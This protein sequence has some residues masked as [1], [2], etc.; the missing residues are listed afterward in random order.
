MCKDVK[1]LVTTC[2]I[3]QQMKD[4][5]LHPATLLQFLPIPNQIFEDIAMD[6]ITCLPSSKGKF[7]I[8]T[9]VDRLTKYDHFIP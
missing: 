6:F 5:N 7:T 9:V 4:T 3:C 1:S 2:Q 8:L